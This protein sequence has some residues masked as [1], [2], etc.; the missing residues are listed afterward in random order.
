MGGRFYPPILLASIKK[1]ILNRVKCR[2]LVILLYVDTEKWIASKIKSL[3]SLSLIYK[4]VPEVLDFATISATYYV[5]EVSM[6]SF[7]TTCIII[8]V[9]LILFNPISPGGGGGVKLARGVFKFK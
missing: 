6:T 7:V 1:P 3:H 2:N 8:L 9:E 4:N 5:I